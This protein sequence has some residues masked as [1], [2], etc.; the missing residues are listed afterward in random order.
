M[1]DV[2]PRISRKFFLLGTADKKREYRGMLMKPQAVVSQI[3]E[4]MTQVS[5]ADPR[6][7]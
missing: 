3:R 1:H 7:D 4:A 5:K 2:S 6:T